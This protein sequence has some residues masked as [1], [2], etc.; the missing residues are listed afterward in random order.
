LQLFVLVLAAWLA[1][2]APAAALALTLLGYAWHSF[3]AG[4][5][6]QSVAALGPG[7][8]VTTPV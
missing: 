4:A 7:P 5:I 8:L 2:R 3:G 6:A 1:L